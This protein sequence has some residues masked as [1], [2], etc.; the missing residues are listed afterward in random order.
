M[1]LVVTT[2]TIPG[3]RVQS[4][5]GPVVGLTMRSRNPYKAGLATL[6]GGA[7]PEAADQLVQCRQEAITE[8]VRS[9]R[10]RG[11]NAIIG[12]RFDHRQVTNSTA[13]MCAY[14]TA[15]IVVPEAQ[16]VPRTA[17][18]LAPAGGLS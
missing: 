6:D 5:L 11:A 14:G 3:Y 2:E 18:A 10:E 7:H 8:M 17:E 4:V 1:L 9:A 13:E 15:V 16:P 12:M